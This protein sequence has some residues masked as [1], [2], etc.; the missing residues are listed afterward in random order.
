MNILSV[1]NNAATNTVLCQQVKRKPL[2]SRF[3]K[4]I[5]N[6]P[7]STNATFYSGISDEAGQAIETQVERHDELGWDPL[8]SQLVDGTNITQISDPAFDQVC[9]VLQKANRKASCFGSAENQPRTSMAN[10][11]ESSE[12]TLVASNRFPSQT[13]MVSSRSLF[14]ATLHSIRAFVIGKRS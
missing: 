6:A 12:G 7:L 8:D 10:S 2:F 13:R 5:H 11:L 1:E 9:E 3:N 4:P 14:S